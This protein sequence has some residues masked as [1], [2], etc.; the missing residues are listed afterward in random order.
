MTK[1]INTTQ[2]IDIPL[3]ETF[4]LLQKENTL[5]ST[6]QKR[7]LTQKTLCLHKFK[8]S[9]SIEEEKQLQMFGLYSR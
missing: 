3:L 9:K 6:E 1:I 2:A 7:Q 8:N 4:T 5:M